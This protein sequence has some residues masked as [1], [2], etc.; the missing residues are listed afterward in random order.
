MICSLAKTPIIRR[1]YNTQARHRDDITPQ[2]IV[3]PVKKQTHLFDFKPR[4]LHNVA[5]LC[6]GGGS[7]HGAVQSEKYPLNLSG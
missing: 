1:G 7:S 6:L 4:P 2:I 3:M 5:A